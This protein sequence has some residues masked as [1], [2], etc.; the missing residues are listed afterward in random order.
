[1]KFSTLDA[2]RIVGF[3]DKVLHSIRHT[4][5][6][7]ADDG[8]NGET[9]RGIVLQL[10]AA[11]RRERFLAGY[12]SS[13]E[14]NGVTFEP[15]T[16]ETVDEAARAADRLAEIAA[17]KERDYAA[18]VDAAA[19]VVNATAEAANIRAHA[20]TLARE[21][22]ALCRTLPA[23][24]FPEAARTLAAAIVRARRDVLKLR[25]EAAERR[26]QGEWRNPEAFRET[27]GE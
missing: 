11:A 18:A 23:E 15:S 5:W 6:F 2:F 19:F 8:W 4:G 20:L 1:M 9:L 25:A 14:D 3:A 21:R 22:R 12:V 13:E 27:L 10:P 16:H 17:E 24:S 26:E 7:T